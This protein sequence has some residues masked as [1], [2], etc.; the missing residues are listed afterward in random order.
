MYFIIK[1]VCKIC[2]FLLKREVDICHTVQTEHKQSY[3]GDKTAGH[4]GESSGPESHA[5]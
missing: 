4:W 2:P 5:G 3:L 1:I